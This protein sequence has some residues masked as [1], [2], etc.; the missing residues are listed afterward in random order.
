MNQNVSI[1]H[2]LSIFERVLSWSVYD[3]MDI[4]SLIIHVK[5]SSFVSYNL[6]NV[7]ANHLFS[8]L[9]DGDFDPP[10]SKSDNV[11]MLVYND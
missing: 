3:C 10:T 1:W 6:K 9:F 5:E 7:S 2:A 11:S 4:I 8:L